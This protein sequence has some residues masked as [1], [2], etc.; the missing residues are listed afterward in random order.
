MA[1]ATDPL[2]ATPT[3]IA[4]LVTAGQLTGSP[5]VKGSGDWDLS[6]AN[7][8]SHAVVN[9]DICAAINKQAGQTVAADGS[10]AAID[11]TF[12]CLTDGTSTFTFQFKY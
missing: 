1:R 3:A 6:V 7:V 12:G 4:D 8:I 2:G 9:T 5:V 11:G 10:V